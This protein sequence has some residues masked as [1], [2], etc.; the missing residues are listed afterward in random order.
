[1]F[2]YGLLFVDFPGVLGLFRGS[3]A[4]LFREHFL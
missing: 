3:L 1:M 4:Y 2:G